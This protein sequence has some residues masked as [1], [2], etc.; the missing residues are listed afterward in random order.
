[1]SLVTL[2]IVFAIVLLVFGGALAVMSIG[3]S[4][5]GRCMRGSCGGPEVAGPGG[6]A[7]SCRD[8]PNRKKRAEA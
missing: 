4:L 8:C 5:T 2:A 6:E 3:Q 7:L 1:M